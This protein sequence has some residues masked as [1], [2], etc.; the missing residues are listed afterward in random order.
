VADFKTIFQGSLLSS[1][2]YFSILSNFPEA[3]LLRVDL[4][5]LDGSEE[6][7]GVLA[8]EG[9]SLVVAGEG[10]LACQRHATFASTSPAAD[11]NK[12][13]CFYLL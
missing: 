2:L 3:D 9:V 11:R 7:G 6:G 8:G 13:G 5:E 10:G 4:S 12:L 1:S